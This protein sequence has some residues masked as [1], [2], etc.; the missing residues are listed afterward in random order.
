MFLIRDNFRVYHSTP[1]KAWAAENAQKIE[2][3][4]L[5]SY[6]PE[7]NPKQKLNADLKHIFTS[8]VP[9]RTKA[10]LRAATA[11][12]MTM[13]EQNPEHVRHYFDDPQIAYAAS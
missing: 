11:D 13:L 12:Y 10:K 1:V 3:F 7:L 9:V 2:L 8:K 4:Y 6:S 5:P